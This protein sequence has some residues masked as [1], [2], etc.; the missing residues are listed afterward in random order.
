LLSNDLK[1]KSKKIGRGK[2]IDILGAN[3]INSSQTF[4]SRDKQTPITALS[5]KKSILV[6]K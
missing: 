2:F 6:A 5:I 4:L 3:L 1:K